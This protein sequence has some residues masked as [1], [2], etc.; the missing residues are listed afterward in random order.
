MSEIRRA[1]GMRPLTE[2]RKG[3]ASLSPLQSILAKCAE[4]CGDFAD[5]NQD[6]KIPG[7]PLYPYM[8]YGTAKRRK[9]HMSEEHKA[10]LAEAAKR[11]LNPPH[12]S[13]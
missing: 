2:Y 13:K 9:R 12:K 11:R 7:C 10:K 3:N 4:C 5:G 6:C 1:K 8:P